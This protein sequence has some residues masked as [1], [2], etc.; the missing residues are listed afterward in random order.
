M[1]QRTGQQAHSSLQMRSNKRKT[2]VTREVGLIEFLVSKVGDKMATKIMTKTKTKHRKLHNH[3][4][5]FLKLPLMK[6]T[7]RKNNN[8]KDKH[9]VGFGKTGTKRKQDE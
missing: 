4:K 8:E 5:G 7:K 1:D 6:L 2:E 9:W 3:F